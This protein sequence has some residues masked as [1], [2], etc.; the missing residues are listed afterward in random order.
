MHLAQTTKFKQKFWG[1]FSQLTIDSPE[2]Q[3]VLGKLW[4]KD[5]YDVGLVKGT[6]PLH[7]TPKSPYRPCQAQY[8]LKPE[9][10]TGITPVFKSLLKTRV[11]IPCAHSPVRMSIK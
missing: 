6:E 1:N 9:A 5:K 11:V 10:I 8:P 3:E 4:A 2:L 7:V